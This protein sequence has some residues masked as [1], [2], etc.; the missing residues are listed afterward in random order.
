[1]AVDGREGKTE[2][3]GVALVGHCGPDS[4]MLKSMIKRTLPDAEVYKV[5]SAKELEKT[6]GR[7]RV[8]LVNRVLGGRFGTSSGVELIRDLVSQNGDGPAAI[9]ISNY[10]DA[11]AEAEAAGAL[12]GFGKSGLNSPSVAERLNDAFNK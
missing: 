3:K 11:Q 9:L 12:P 7:T 1:M 10:E 5:D 6:I 2:A 4:W 8:L